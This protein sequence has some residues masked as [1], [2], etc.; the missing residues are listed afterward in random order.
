MQDFY[1]KLGDF[2]LSLRIGDFVQF[3][4]ASAKF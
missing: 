1:V 2:M 4:G 3:S